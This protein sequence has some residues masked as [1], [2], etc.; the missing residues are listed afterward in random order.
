MTTWLADMH[1]SHYATVA[2]MM[3]SVDSHHSPSY[4]RNSYLVC[5]LNLNMP[6]CQ[7]I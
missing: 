2:N 3:V 6:F 7:A 4:M 1:S 5:V